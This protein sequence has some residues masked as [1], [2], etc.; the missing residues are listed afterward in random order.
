MDK[1]DQKITVRVGF[2][3]VL[4]T[5]KWYNKDLLGIAD[6]ILLRE[7]TAWDILV[8]ELRDRVICGV[9]RRNKL[10]KW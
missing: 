7:F 5:Q 2:Y 3:H 6:F 4:H 9:P 1:G 8:D 10:V